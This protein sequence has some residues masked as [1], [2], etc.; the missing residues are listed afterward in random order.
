MPTKGGSELFFLSVDATEAH[1]S[2]W[3]R[4]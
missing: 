3:A 1:E 2:S 4:G